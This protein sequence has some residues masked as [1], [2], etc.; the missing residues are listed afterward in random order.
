MWDMRHIRAHIDPGQERL[1]GCTEASF[2]DRSVQSVSL[3]THLAMAFIIGVILPAHRETERG[4]LGN[5][6]VGG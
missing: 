3:V 6:E 1:L 4:P 2:K 5:T